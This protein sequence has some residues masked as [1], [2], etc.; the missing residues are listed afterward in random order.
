MVQSTVAESEVTVV[1]YYSASC[2]SCKT[3]KELVLE[4]E[5]NY[6]GDNI[7]FIRKEVGSNSTN[8]AEWKSYGFIT[9]PSI[10]INNETKIPKDNITREKLVVIIDEYLAKVNNSQL[11]PEQRLFLSVII[12]GAVL[13]LVLLAVVIWRKNR[14]GNN[15]KP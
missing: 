4:L 11:Q 10:V 12:A 6:T 8:H 5:Q 3:A 7:V 9:Y 13:G 15:K 2:G 14:K 1:L